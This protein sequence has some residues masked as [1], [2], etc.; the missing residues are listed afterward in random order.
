MS[1]SRSSRNYVGS[2]GDDGIAVH[3]RL[4]IELSMLA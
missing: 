1:A 4:Y 3:R 2:V